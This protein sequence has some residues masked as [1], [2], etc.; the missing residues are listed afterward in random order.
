MEDMFTIFTIVS[1]GIIVQILLLH[2]MIRDA[3]SIKFIRK[4][5]EANRNLLTEIARKH[6]VEE[7][8]IENILQEVRDYPS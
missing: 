8:K 1:V 5:M 2:W 3:V 6:G 4:N 7:S